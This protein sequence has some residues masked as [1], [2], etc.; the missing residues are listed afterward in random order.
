MDNEHHDLEERLAGLVPRAVSDE[1]TGRLEG[2]IDRLVASVDFEGRRRKSWLWPSLGAAACLAGS[3]VVFSGDGRMGPVGESGVVDK[4]VVELV[5]LSRQ[6]TGVSESDWIVGDGSARPF[7]YRSYE[8]TG[9]ERFFDD[10]SGL[11]VT[12]ISESEER[13]P[14]VMTQL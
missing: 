9:T 13:V 8:I 14:M 12:V 7:R 11:S 6:V 2:E 1:G 4:R 3:F 5:S 10:E